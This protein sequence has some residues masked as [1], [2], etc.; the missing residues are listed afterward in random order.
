MISFR[1]LGL[2]SAVLA[3]ARAV[4]AVDVLTWHDDLA[5]TGQNLNETILKPANVNFNQFG[6]LF[7]IPTD[8]QVYAQPL[9]VSNLAIPGNGIHNVV[10][11][12]T[13]Q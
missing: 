1:K 12:A 11:I 8:G 7:I 4:F 13:E 2:F 9:Y 6:K 5:R 3:A 10:Y